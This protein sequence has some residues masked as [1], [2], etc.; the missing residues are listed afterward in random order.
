ME[1]EVDCLFASLKM[2]LL[3]FFQVMTNVDFMENSLTRVDL[4]AKG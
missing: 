4:E 2:L 1:I 3:N